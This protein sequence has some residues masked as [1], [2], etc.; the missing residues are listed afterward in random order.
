MRVALLFG[1]VSR[2]RYDDGPFFEGATRW[3][4]FWKRLSVSEGDVAIRFSYAR[5]WVEV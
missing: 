4:V 5:Y 3:G 1:V 2:F